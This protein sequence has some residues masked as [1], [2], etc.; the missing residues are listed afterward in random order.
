MVE[1]GA[2]VGVAQIGVRIDL[3]H[4][5]ARMLGRHRRDHGRRDGVLAAEDDRKFVVRDQGG[6]HAPNLAHQIAHV[7]ERQL[8]FRQRVD[9]DAVDV[10]VHLLVPE[11][12]V[13]GR[14]Q[15]LPRT[16]SGSRPV[17]RR[18]LREES[19]ESP[20][21]RSRRWQRPAG[22]RRRRAVSGDRNETAASWRLLERVA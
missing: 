8:H 16:I 18:A 14:H 1:P 6:R 13:R 12:H 10:G 7:V 9:A 22:C 5:E 19:A 20:L 11:L 4:R 21:W 3:Q 15:N 17:R 2:H